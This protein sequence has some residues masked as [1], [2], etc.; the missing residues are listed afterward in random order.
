MIKRLF[1]IIVVFLINLFLYSC[2]NIEHPVSNEFKLKIFN[3]NISIMGFNDSYN[4]ENLVINEEVRYYDKKD[5]EYKTGFVL[6]VEENAFRNKNLKSI[7]F[8]V[9]EK[10][11]FTQILDYAFADNK[12][13]TPI[14]LPKTIIEIGD[15]AFANS[16]SIEIINLIEIKVLGNFV[17][18]N[19]EK[20]EEID[21]GSN[22]NTIGN[23]AF[24]NC[25]DNLI[26]KISNP[27]PPTI[28]ENIFKNVNS[29][30]IIVP[31]NLL[32]IYKNADGWSDYSSNIF[33]IN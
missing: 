1:L 6:R 26:I 10:S 29:F 24:E 4:E 11:K 5:K 25:N 21:L 17:F 27:I 7:T 22:I 20:L 15:Y 13:L 23:N 12:D 2:E 28:G 31:L 9:T 8:N 14:I 33:T 19:C 32:E 30:I 18:M 16:S 3:D